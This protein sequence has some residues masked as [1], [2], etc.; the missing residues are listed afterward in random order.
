LLDAIAAAVP[1]IAEDI[2]EILEVLDGFGSFVGH[3][4]RRVEQGI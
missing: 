4:Y 2:E 1:I 3:R